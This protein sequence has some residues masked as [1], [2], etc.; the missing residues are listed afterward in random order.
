MC[1]LADRVTTGSVLATGVD[2]TPSMHFSW[3]RV[4][5]DTALKFIRPELFWPPLRLCVL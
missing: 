2:E 4:C 3:A 5:C 1:L